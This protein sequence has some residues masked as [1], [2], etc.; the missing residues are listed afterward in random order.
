MPFPAGSMKQMNTLNVSQKIPVPRVRRTHVYSSTW[1][2]MLTMMM[3]GLYVCVCVIKFG[4]YCY[5]FSFKERKGV[6]ER[7]GSYSY[8]IWSQLTRNPPASICDTLSYSVKTHI[9]GE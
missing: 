5:R 6:R 2:M 3:I 4:K 7:K 8:M 1:R 9:D